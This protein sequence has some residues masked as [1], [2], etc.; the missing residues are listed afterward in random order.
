GGTLS[1]GIPGTLSPEYS[2]DDK[3]VALSLAFDIYKAA[4]RPRTW[5]LL[6]KKLV[7]GNDELAMHLGNYLKPPVQSLELRS[8]TQQN[9]KW[10]IIAKADRKKQ[11]SYHAGMK[12]SLS[13]NLD[14]ARSEL[15][16]KPGTITNSLCYLFDQTRKNKNTTWRWTEYNWKMLE[17][18]F[19]EDVAHFYRDGVVSFWRYHVPKLRSEGAPFNETPWAVIIG[20]A[21]LEIEA[22]E[23]KGW[24]KNMGIAEVELACKYASFELNGFP[25]WFPRLFE[26]YPD[27]VCDFLMREIRYELSIEKPETDPNYILCDVIWYG[28]WAWD[29]LAPSIYDYLKAREPINLSNLDKL[30][31]IVQGSIFPDELIEELVAR[32][33]RILKEPDHLSRWLAVWTGVAPE[34]AI[35]SFKARIGEM[36]DQKEQTLFAMTFAT[37][38]FTGRSDERRGDVNVTRQAFKTP[39]YLKSLYLLMHKYIRSQEDINHTEEAEA[40]SPGLRDDAQDARNS[41]FNLL[42]NIHGK[43]S[44]F[45]LIDIAKEHPDEAF[46]PWIMLHAKTNAEQHGDMIPWQPSQVRDFQESQERTPSNHRELAELAVL[47][48]LDLK[49][50]LEQG[51]S[52]VASILKIVKQETEIRKYI[53]NALRDKA[54]GRYSIPQEEEFADAK[55]P[56][57]RFHGAGFDGPVPVELKLADNWSGPKLFERLE[58]QLC[59]DYLRDNRSSRGIYVLV[60]RGET[61]HWE[62]PDSNDRVDF[63]GL[64]IAL[65]EQWKRISPTFLKIDNITVIGIDLT[66]RSS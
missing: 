29:K 18:E 47:R 3:L 60:Y 62:L 26:M 20:L 23:I 57:L 32:K 53:G 40:Y 58:N 61:Q 50:D 63:V 22:I 5:R 38:L 36:A 11:D 33:C 56:D 49:D 30:L 39:A 64:I 28:Q 46:R 66:K 35:A 48:L 54:F 27:I 2:I 51:D 44:F 42:I 12:K 41:L 7:K 17:P 59:I 52:S 37:H 19:G 4:N 45:A 31:K 10:K 43:E 14:E 24:P 55:K 1:P 9:A 65:Q 34:A 16:E 8:L 15:L 25:S 6:L 21:G 13:E